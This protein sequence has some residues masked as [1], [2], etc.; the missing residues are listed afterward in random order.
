MK[1]RLRPEAVWSQVRE[2]GARIE[3]TP[4]DNQCKYVALA[5]DRVDCLYQHAGSA[6]PDHSCIWDFAPGVLLAAEAG[7]E[8]TDRLSAP[9]DFDQGPTLARNRGLTATSPG[10]RRFLPP[11]G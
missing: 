3:P 2:R 9:F 8:V 11:V 6:S 5:T 1:V 7:A 10:T 4:I